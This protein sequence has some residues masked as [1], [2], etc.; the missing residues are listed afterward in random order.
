[1]ENNNSF[2]L[3]IGESINNNQNMIK[4]IAKSE[5]DYIEKAVEFAE[6]KEYLSNTKREIRNNALKSPLF[7]IESFAENFYKMLSSKL[8]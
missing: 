7:D 8:K 1:M 3:R 6:N 5:D 4:W 2:Y